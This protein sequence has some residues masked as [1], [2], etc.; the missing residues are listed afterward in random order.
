[1]DNNFDLEKR[2]C[3]ACEA[4]NDAR[5]KFCME[6]GAKLL[7]DL[8]PVCGAQ[9]GKDAKFCRECGC[10]LQKSQEPKVHKEPKPQQKMKRLTKAEVKESRAYATIKSSL[11]LLISAL[12]LLFS[13]LPI[14]TFEFDDEFGFDRDNAIKIS[15]TP[16]E[17]TMFL[18]DSI[19]ENDEEDMKLDSFYD[20]YEDA[21]EEVQD[22]RNSNGLSAKDKR[23]IEK[24]AKLTVRLGLRSDT[25]SLSPQFIVLA[26]FSILYVAFALAFFGMSLYQFVRTL[27][28]KEPSYRLLKIALCLSPF[29]VLFTYLISKGDY[30]S[31]TMGCGTPSLIISLVGIVIVA[32]DGYIL[33]GNRLSIKK[34]LTMGICLCFLVASMFLAF[35]SAYGVEITE[36]RSAKTEFSTVYFQEFEL[37]D[38]ML[39]ELS[40]STSDD[41]KDGVESIA[42]SFTVKE[43]RDGDADMSIS[44]ALSLAVYN[45]LEDSCV[46]LSLIYYVAMLAGLLFAIAGFAV[47]A[48]L[49]NGTR[50]NKAIWALVIVAI[51]LTVAYLVL[52]IVFIEMV[53]SIFYRYYLETIIDMKM[54]ASPIILTVCS[55]LALVALVVS[56]VL[57]SKK[58][59]Q[60]NDK[61]EL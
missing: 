1:M 57:E 14:L 10:N 19:I 23:A 5:A 28:K 17:N 3:K 38:K 35:G 34:A 44:M 54:A 48:S 36:E 41:I 43:I 59:K 53:D 52:D 50:V 49:C 37:N 15:F 26:L 8:C 29:V 56:R 42:E 2:I 55:V 58:A 7:S 30:I 12:V 46:A 4:E 18:F 11:F 24:F 47:T 33:H 16:I 20:K 51:L 40:D 6:C 60:A 21:L 13:F 9:T 32:L 45:W 61:I 39:K 31:T 25:I 27:M 22:I